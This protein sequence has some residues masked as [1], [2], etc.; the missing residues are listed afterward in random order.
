MKNC[1]KYVSPSQICDVVG[2]TNQHR[3]KYESVAELQPFT[4]VVFLT[5][6]PVHTNVDSTFT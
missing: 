2:T 3:V 1:T 6:H 4:F 5:E